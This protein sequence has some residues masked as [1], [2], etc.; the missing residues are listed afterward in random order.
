MRV[1]DEWLFKTEPGLSANSPPLA[2]AREGRA[3]PAAP[4]RGASNPCRKL[5]VMYELGSRMSGDF[6]KIA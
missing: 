5:K 4:W 6:H 1:A 2:D 3:V